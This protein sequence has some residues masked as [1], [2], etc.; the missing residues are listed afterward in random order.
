MTRQD[1][2]HVLGLPEN[3]S[4]E[5]VQQKY[6]ELFNDF[7]MRLTNAPTPNLK[8]LYQKNIDELADAMRALGVD[9]GDISDLPASGP[10]FNSAPAQPKRYQEA[11]AQNAAAAPQVGRTQQ[12]APQGK[13][14][15]TLVLIIGFVALLGFA[16]AAF[17]GI[18]LGD[19][20]KKLAEFDLRKA[21]NDTLVALRNNLTNNKFSVKNLGQESI[22]IKGVIV[23]Y[24]QDGKFKKYYGGYDKEIKPG[25][26]EQLTCVK[27][28]KVVWDGSVTSY[29]CIIEYKGARKFR[30]GIWFRDAAKDGVLNLNLDE[31]D[32]AP[33]N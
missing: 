4:L 31:A 8:K 28:S 21:Q 13:S 22:F 16:V 33:D 5:D 3:S 15:N 2:Y 14:S 12:A 23:D 20:S 10:V 29:F 17:F 30:A 11:P 25:T 32:P 9:Q 26:T 7:Q 27:G 18:K 19:S 24:I 1:A 6:N